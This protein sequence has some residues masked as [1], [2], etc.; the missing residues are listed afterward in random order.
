[1]FDTKTVEV[2]NKRAK[3]YSQMGE[4][5]TNKHL[6]DYVGLLKKGDRVLDLGCGHGISSSFMSKA[7]LVC[8]PIDASQKMVELANKK[9]NIGARVCSFEDLDQSQK[10]HG[11]YASFS[12]L[13]VEKSEFLSLLTVL[14]SMLLSSGNLGLGM[15]LGEGVSRDSLGRFY[16]Y[17]SEFELKKFLTNLGLKVINRYSGKDAGLTGD[18]EPWLF[19]FGKKP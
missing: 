10:Y 1:M 18:V 5:K 19:L 7:G 11:I 14:E 13:H 8:D 12:L 4:G 17:Y 15:K 3:E 2:Y 16:A 9:F 6:V